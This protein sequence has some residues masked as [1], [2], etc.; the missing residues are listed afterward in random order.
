MK[1]IRIALEQ[2]YA[3]PKNQTGIAEICPDAEVILFS[4]GDRYPLARKLRGVLRRILPF[5]AYNAFAKHLDPLA[6]KQ[7]LTW[8]KAIQR[9]SDVSNIL[10]FPPG[11]NSDIAEQ[12]V[13]EFQPHWVHSI[14]TGVDK[15]PKLPEGAL[16]SSSKGV[17]SRRIAEFVMGMI[18]ASAKN[19]PQHTLQT[20]NRIWK[21]LPSQQISGA[22]LGVVGLGSIGTEIAKLGKAV[23][24]EVWA[25]RQNI[26]P[27]DIADTVF[28]PEEL[29]RLLKECD[30]IVLSVPL[31]PK[32]HHL[33][34]E[35]QF[36][37]MKPSSCLI[38]ICRGAVIDE[39]ALYQALKTAKIR[40]ACIDVFQ[41][42]KPI[43]KNSR[44][45]DLPNLLIS[46]FSA[47]YSN[48]SVQQVMDLFFENL[49][50]FCNT[51][52]LLSR[53]EPKT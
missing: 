20:R 48:D 50:R 25:M 18:F 22:K 1:K 38:N 49:R 44:F 51:E 23:G 10:L 52:A 42:E 45:Y 21:S 14:T 37:L 53:S 43:P 28:P 30:Y 27:S 26:A 39:D 35:K 16:L 12:L 36:K 11:M 29:P 5:S 6:E 33:I 15:I 34:G 46:S 9:D 19:V 17:H 3:S 32:T 13:T 7:V 2:Q 31:T 47:Y 4:V 40:A 41:D 24:M 8:T